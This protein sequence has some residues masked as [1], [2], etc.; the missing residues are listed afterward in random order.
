MHIH[1]RHTHPYPFPTCSNSG[2]TL[3]SLLSHL[4]PTPPHPIVHTEQAFDSLPPPSQPSPSGPPSAPHCRHSSSCT[5]RGRLLSCPAIDLGARPTLSTCIPPKH[6]LTPDPRFRGQ[7]EGEGWGH[8]F[9]ACQHVPSFH[10]YCKG[11]QC[12][13]RFWSIEHCFSA[14]ASSCVS[15]LSL[16][17]WLA[18][19]ELPPRYL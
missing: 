8:W 12:A 5:P 3:P 6:L 16:G 17:T 13:G 1:K 2:Q 10:T 15:L 7:H 11:L 4:D 18:I 19:Y 9:G 14:S